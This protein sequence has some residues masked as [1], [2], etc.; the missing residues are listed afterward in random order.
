MFKTILG[1]M[2][3]CCRLGILWHVVHLMR[4]YIIIETIQKNVKINYSFKNTLI[5][6]NF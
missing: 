4:L 3:D 5:F 6:F 1:Y 2:V